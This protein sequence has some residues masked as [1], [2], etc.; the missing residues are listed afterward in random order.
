M[1][2]L[3]LLAKTRQLFVLLHILIIYLCIMIVEVV[4]CLLLL[5][6]IVV[7]ILC[8]SFLYVSFEHKTATTR[9]QSKG[10]VGV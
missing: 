2:T 5:T 4:D 6:C 8:F 7:D 10:R 1:F 3:I 9:H